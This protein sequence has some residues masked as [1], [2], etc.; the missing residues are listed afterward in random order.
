M[1][2]YTVTSRDD[3]MRD[4]TQFLVVGSYTSRGR[5]LDECV[6][7][8]LGRLELRDDLAWSMA[9]DEN[10][11]EAAK[12]FA[13]HP[14]EGKPGIVTMKVKKGCKKKL[15]ELLRDELGGTGCYY[16]YDGTD[17]WHFDVDENDVEGALWTT[18]TWGDSDCEDIMFTTPKPETFVSK[19]AAIKDFVEYARGLFASAGVNFKGVERLIRKQ[20]AEEGRCQV[21]LG[22]GTCV[23]CVLYS[24]ELASWKE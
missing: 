21:D 1:T 22:D 15:R 19:D 23:S 18:V 6:D 12:L 24:D 2:I 5:A 8:I 20:M 13:E 3:K 17:S 14:V 9:N 10:H 4:S 16:V 7:Y 11:P